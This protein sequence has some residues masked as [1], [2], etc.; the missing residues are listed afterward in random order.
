MVLQGKT[1]RI[2]M[3]RR[4]TMLWFMLLWDCLY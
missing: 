3:H 1:G 4:N 2:A